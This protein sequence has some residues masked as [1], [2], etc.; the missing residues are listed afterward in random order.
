M[1]FGCWNCKG[2][3]GAADLSACGQVG[4]WGSGRAPRIAVATVLALALLAAGCGTPDSGNGEAP[5]A[6][7][8]YRA[9]PASRGLLPPESEGID[10]ALALADTG[11]LP[12]QG[13]V[14]PPADVAA[15]VLT[16]AV[17][18]APESELSLQ[19]CTDW[20]AD[21]EFVLEPV[22]AQECNAIL[23][24]AVGT[25]QELHCFAAPAD[26]APPGTVPADD[27]PA[28]TAP[29]DTAPA[30]TAP[31]DTAPADT[32][33]ADTAPADTDPAAVLPDQAAADTGAP[34]ST[35]AAEPDPASAPEGGHP[36]LPLAQMVP[37]DEPYWDYPT[38]TGSPPWP[39][40]CYPPSEW[41]IHQD[42]SDC[43]TPDVAGGVCASR[44][45]DETPRQTRDV[46][47]WSSWC[48]GWRPISCEYLLS[49]M[50][51][52]LDYLGAHPWCVLGQYSHRLAQVHELWREG[53][54]IPD[55]IRNGYGWHRCPSVIDPGQP[56]DPRRRLSETGI[57]L[58][59]Q[60]RIVL[61]AEVR[62][63]TTTDNIDVAP[64]RFGSDCDAWAAWVA[65]RPAARHWRDCDRSARLAEEW[66]EHH[67]GSS[68]HY[69]PVNC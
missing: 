54:R 52:A 6:E 43:W 48:D 39:S 47:E 18:A 69:F 35:V 22:R 23:T 3:S 9:D 50:K 63:E 21:P 19:D 44:K 33:P 26:T 49:E 28:D 56:D 57:S 14:M 13:P 1:S 37:R 68:E 11:P 25:C 46:V 36:P 64:E 12:E 2:R 8:P 51:W 16:A 31:A 67:Y 38:C 58:A 4:G 45:P 34:A 32:A 30:D 60:C 17:E 65:N 24:A 41:E 66:M 20:I 42:L 10:P 15:R 55:D 59:E 27:V 5:T 61:P 7:P 40:D 62:L 29:A 53:S